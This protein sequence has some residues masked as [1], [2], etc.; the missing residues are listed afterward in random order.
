MY[1]HTVPPSPNIKQNNVLNH[2]P[3]ERCFIFF[4]QEALLPDQ[5]AI[6]GVC[7][8]CADSVPSGRH[9]IHHAGN[10][11]RGYHPGVPNGRLTGRSY[12]VL[13]PRDL[14]WGRYI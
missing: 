11:V 1:F 3:W 5:E 14:L 12:V 7:G 6:R 2:T 13:V 4:F 10:R 8:L 9:G